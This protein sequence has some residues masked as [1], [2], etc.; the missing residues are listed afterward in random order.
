MTY[1]YIGGG[2]WIPGVPARDLT[3][4]EYN[5]HKATIEANA[6]AMGTPMYVA[7]APVEDARAAEVETGQVDVPLTDDSEDT[8]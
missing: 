6:V 4:E 2:D 1:T 8:D 7:D 5:R 3:D